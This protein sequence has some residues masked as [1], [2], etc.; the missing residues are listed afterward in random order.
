M[1]V[2]G[3]GTRSAP[4]TDV[5]SCHP[6]RVAGPGGYSLEKMKFCAQIMNFFT[7]DYLHGTAVCHWQFGSVLLNAVNIW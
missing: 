1:L 3:G 4:D 6:S 2:E 7:W 5:L